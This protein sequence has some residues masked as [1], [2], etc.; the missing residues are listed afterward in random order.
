MANAITADRTA[1]LDPVLQ[2][3]AEPHRRAILRLVQHNKMAAG[4][5]A[6]HFGKT[7]PAIS[8]HLRVL[9]DAGLVTM[10]SEGNRRLYRARLQGLAELRRYLEEYRGERLTLLKAAAEAEEGKLKA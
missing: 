10:R 7:R 6:A 9:V 1:A 8:Q 4:E 2:A 3:L 5:I